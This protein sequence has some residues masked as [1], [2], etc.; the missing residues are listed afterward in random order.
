MK[1]T[2]KPIKVE[3][4]FTISAAELWSTITELQHMKQWFFPNIDAFEPAV[5]FH[6]RFIVENEG[7]I[8][9]HLWKITEVIPQ[10]KIMFNWQY[11]GY[12]GNSYVSFEISEHK[13]HQTGPDTSHHQ[14]L[15]FQHS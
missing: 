13:T 3:Q 5:G 2:E 10:R 6:T 1:F 14:R 11:E 4:K 8:F 12:S 9:P 15:P 7:R